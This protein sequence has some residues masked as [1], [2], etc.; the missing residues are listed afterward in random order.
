[1][2]KPLLII[3]AVLLLGGALTLYFLYRQ[4]AKPNLKLPEKSRLV[5]IPRGADGQTVYDSLAPYLLDSA[6]FFWVAEKKSYLS[7]VKPG[8]YRLK[9]GWSNEQ[10]IDH[11]RS[12]DQEPLNVVVHNV[13]DFPDLAQLLGRKL[14]PSA[15]SFAQFFSTPD[16]LAQLALDRQS[17]YQAVIPNTYEFYWTSRPGTVLKKLKRSAESFWEE[18]ADALERTPL[19]RH[20]VV[21]LASIVQSET[22]Q[23]DEMPEVA[24]LYLNRLEQGIKL[25][26]DPT[27]IYAVEKA[28]PGLNIRRVLYRHLRFASPYNTYRHK[29]LPP[30]PI[31]L[32]GKAALEA[33]LHPAAHDYIFMVADP[34]NPGYHLFA[35]TL[36]EHNQNRRNYI[37]WLNRQK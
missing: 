4:V 37:Q 22:S 12:G 19:N 16:S 36:Q 30:G 28:N 29:G 26:S 35:K 5:Y 20:E 32:P 10:L 25:Q 9:D 31:R 34:K 11:L 7:Q 17:R 15:E 18:E 21:T 23:P 24:E 3:L 13:S 2:K 14:A 6:S 8:R 33:V 1:L 27:V